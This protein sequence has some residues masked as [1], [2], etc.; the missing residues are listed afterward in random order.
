MR[1]Q[2]EVNIGNQPCIELMVVKSPLCSHI[3]AVKVQVKKCSKMVL[4]KC[5]CI[6]LLMRLV[7]LPSVLVIPITESTSAAFSADTKSSPSAI[8]V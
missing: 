3:V 8:N 2:F 7:H 5:I 1:C 4:Y 6:A